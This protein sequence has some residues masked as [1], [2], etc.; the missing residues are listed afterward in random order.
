ME[1]RTTATLEKIQE[2]ALAEFLDKGFHRG[3]LRLLLQQ[4]GPVQRP[5][6]APCRCPYGQVH[7]G[8]DLLCRAA[9]GAAAIPH[10]G[11]I[12]DLFGLD[13]GLHLSAPGAGKAA[14]HPLRGHQLRALRPQHGGGGG[15]IH[16]PIHGFS[17]AW[18]R[19]FPSWTNPYVTSS[20]AGCS[21]V[22]SRLWSTICPGSRPCGMWINSAISTLPDG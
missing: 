11:G 14:P 8:P 15:R 3:L 6:G 12:R 4:G 2:A 7:G 9:R 19:T 16:P 20:P 22:S 10:G 21:M 17:A 1:E 18:E 5:G 13:G